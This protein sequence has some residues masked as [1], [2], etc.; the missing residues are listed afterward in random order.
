MKLKE[1]INKEIESNEGLSLLKSLWS[2][3]RYRSL[4]WLILY[5]IFFTII[6]VSARNDYS[7]LEE[8]ELP[9]EPDIN[10]SLNI[11]ESLQN[12]RDY[13]Y[14]IL[15]NE[16]ESLI[17]GEV[18][19]NTN[20]F[21]YDNENYIIVGNNIYLENELTL[22][23]VDLLENSDLIIP[24]D[25]I[26]IENILNY[27]KGVEP[28]KSGHSI[29]YNISMSNIF[30][31]ETISFVITFFGKDKVENVKLDFTDYVKYKGLEYEQYVLTIKLGKE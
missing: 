13:S 1:R 7:N 20:T 30:E 22:T 11:D 25:K 31:E 16:E 3:K 19:D 15:L 17:I 21:V 28:I 4:F 2:N 10:I 18:K 6:I 9:K 26:D 23:K 8:N 27:I 5:F 12:L 29:K 14:E 24:I